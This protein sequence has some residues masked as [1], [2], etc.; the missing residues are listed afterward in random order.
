MSRPTDDAASYFSMAQSRFKKAMSMAA[1]GG[2]TA[3]FNLAMGY[4]DMCTGLSNL[5]VGLRATYM[6]LEDVRSM[7]QH[8]R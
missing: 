5:N 8:P 1:T 6:L 2:D 7:L 4:L 3:E